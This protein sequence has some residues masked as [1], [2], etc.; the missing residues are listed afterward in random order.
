MSERPQ[1][2]PQTADISRYQA[3]LEISD[4]VAARE[5]I[6]G[7]MHEVAERLHRV[8]D[9]DVVSFVLHDAERGVMQPHVV[10]V[11]EGVRGVEA[12]QDVPVDEAPS[13]WAM[14]RQ[15]PL[16]LDDIASERRFRTVLDVF[17]KA[18]LRAVCAMPMTSSQRQLGGITFA[19][20]RAGAYSVADVDFL[21]RVAQQVAIAMDAALDREAALRVIYAVSG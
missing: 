16:I 21:R 12:P 8:V 17:R 11:S 20:R 13:G 14:Q 4:F 2:A 19:S 1:S 6:S 7:L 15:E 10:E 5:S 9:F 3:L 18:G